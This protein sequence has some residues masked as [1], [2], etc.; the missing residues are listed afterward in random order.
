MRISVVIP[1]YNCEG[2]I[3]ATL[4]RLLPQLTHED[5]IVIV[6]DGSSDGTAATV[7][8]F[9]L[10]H[11][12]IP[13]IFETQSNGGPA[14][15]RNRGLA[16]AS[17][18]Y[19]LFVDADDLPSDRYVSS[20]RS[21]VTSQDGIDIAYGKYLRV[22]VESDSRSFSTPGFSEGMHS[23]SDVLER[24]LTWRAEIS[25]WN[26]IFR[27]SL[28][29]ENHLRFDNRRRIGEDVEFIAKYLSQSRYAYV[30]TDVVYEFYFSY[31]REEKRIARHHS[32]DIRESEYYAI[33]EWLKEYG[34]PA[35][36]MKHYTM[37]SIAL[38]LFMTRARLSSSYSDFR[39]ELKKNRET[40]K[41]LRIPRRRYAA[42]LRLFA[43]KSAAIVL[44]RFFPRIFFKISSNYRKG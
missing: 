41:E 32:T 23:S 24:F 31:D 44:C 8:G 18:E 42:T 34:I 15:A 10:E 26:T 6:N 16:L 43:I 4:E 17:G 9:L 28:I 36:Y 14:S 38:N 39:D 2:T 11:K 7:E 12:S 30:G 5:E 13:I 21:Y 22:E 20:L 25:L 27:R 29:E 40:R 19:V 33:R 3:A 35:R 1:A 37:P